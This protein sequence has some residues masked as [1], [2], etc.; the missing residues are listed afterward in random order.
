MLAALWRLGE[1]EVA[2]RQR[3]SS[4]QVVEGHVAHGSFGPKCAR[5]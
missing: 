4:V 5:S 2:W 1:R 3:S